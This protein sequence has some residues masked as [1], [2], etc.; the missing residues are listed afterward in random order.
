MSS[1]QNMRGRDFDGHYRSPEK[2][3]LGSST[4]A[5]SKAMISSDQ[6][7]RSNA[8]MTVFASSLKDDDLMISASLVD[9][10]EGR[11]MKTKSKLDVSDNL[12]ERL[13]IGGDVATLA[14]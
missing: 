7:V 11:S 3:F 4:L 12:K 10:V 5:Q 14:I 13:L 2:R 6:H 1:T 8:Q 9:P